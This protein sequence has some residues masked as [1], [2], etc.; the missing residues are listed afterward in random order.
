MVAIVIVVG[1]LAR[2]C[3]DDFEETVISETQQRL[4]TIAGLQADNIR[5]HV[6]DH[7]HELQMLAGDLRIKNA[8]INNA[9]AQDILASNGY[10]PEHAVYNGYLQHS[11]NGLYRLDAKGIIQSRIPYKA[12]RMGADF[13]QKPGVKVVIKTH[14]PYISDVFRA[15]SGDRCISICEPVFKDK[16]FIGI[17]RAMVYLKTISKMVVEIKVGKR[18]HAQIFDDDGT[19]IAH[20]D[21]GQ[22]GK[23]IIAV[24]KEA[25]GDYDWSEMETVVARMIRGEEGVGSYHSVWWDA[26]KPKFVKKLTAFA[27]IRLGNEL[28]S[29][30]VTMGYDEISGPIK[31]YARDVGIAAGVLILVFGGIY[32]RF[33][34]I[35]K[36]KAKLTAEAKSADKLRSMN[37]QLAAE[38]TE[39]KRAEE[40]LEEALKETEELNKYL[41][42][43][44]ALANDMTARAEEA[45][46]AK[47]QFL[48]N[49][50]HEIRTPMNAIIGFSDLLAD[51]DLTDEQKV[52]VNIIR[53][54]GK[55]LLALI[56][57]ILDFSRIEAGQLS[58]EMIDCSLAELLNSVG[59]LMRPKVI[60][61]GLE[62]KI[63]E[64]NGLPAQIRSDPTRVQQCLINL[65]GNATKFTKKGHVYVNVSLEVKDNQP[66]IRFDVA[67]TG[68]GI[69][70]DKQEAIFNSFT[71]ADGS[72][73]RQYGGTGLGLTI[74]RQLAEL[75]GGELSLT[76]EVGLGSVF[77]LLIPAGL[78]IYKQPFLD[79]H[80]IS[81]MLEQQYDT[82]EQVKFSGSCLVAEDV[83]ANQMV[84]K[85]ML[86]KAGV[87]VAIANDG[88]EAL[89]QAL[90]KSFDLIF[91][92]IQMPNMNGYEAAKM[93]RKAGMT[94]PIVA[95]TAH[96]MKG[97]DK[98]CIEAGCDDY[99]AKPVELDQLFKILDKYL[100]PAWQDQ[101]YSVAEEI[102]TIKQEVDMLSEICTEPD[103]PDEQQANNK[104]KNNHADSKT[105]Q[106][107]PSE[108]FNCRR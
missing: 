83:L 59:S 102:D 51:E 13:S 17:E 14:K 60:E 80:N 82:S 29:L 77:S 16:Q 85:L 33:Y 40:K 81:E 25:F 104:V 64:S 18:G 34:R 10:S 84:I 100:S 24:R 26:D 65:I 74:T 72:T 89:R 92:D 107:D 44:T 78:D 101:G 41:I 22:G 98:K 23:N 67:D 58:I 99:L 9:S 63:A 5:D 75:L 88:K 90:G 71:Q 12:N 73:T 47:S 54:S 46:M 28:W 55:N 56:N 93:L 37:Q 57:D 68:I 7:Q 45:N 105:S 35:Q 4:L 38:I 43:T 91:M 87:H 50:S 27:P 96:A 36:E 3:T 97:D 42:E 70:K 106:G 2:D 69:P 11:I 19:V 62:F 53:E 21:T 108:V 15:F 94:T 1:I 39:R 76:S 32:L 61:K 103:H 8:I 79:K 30:G 52:E 6:F 86:E 20:P 31:A 48:A 95:L 49:M 66:Y